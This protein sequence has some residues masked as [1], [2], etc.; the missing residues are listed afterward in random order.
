MGEVGVERVNRG[1]EVVPPRPCLNELIS[2]HVELMADNEGVC[3]LEGGDQVELALL[4]LWPHKERGEHL[5]VRGVN[6]L[7]SLLLE[8]DGVL[9]IS[10]ACGFHAL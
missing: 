9:S 1:E 10:M 7:D 2:H 4:F 6:L 5:V 3:V 8:H